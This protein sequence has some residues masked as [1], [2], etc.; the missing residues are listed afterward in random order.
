MK[1]YENVKAKK[2]MTCISSSENSQSINKEDKE[3]LLLFSPI[4]IATNSIKPIFIKHLQVKTLTSD[5]IIQ[6]E[7]DFSH[8]IQKKKRTV[9][10]ATILVHYKIHLLSKILNSYG[11][12]ISKRVTK[13]TRLVCTL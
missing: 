3:I 8:K 4:F 6:Y 12:N 2:Q 1:T 10:K 9:A 7:M 11:G 13:H 5:C